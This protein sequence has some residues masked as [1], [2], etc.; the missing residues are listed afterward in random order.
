MR[1]RPSYWSAGFQPCSTDSL[2]LC[3]G[4]TRLGLAPRGRRSRVPVRASAWQVQRLLP[5]LSQDIRPL[6]TGSQKQ[7]RETGRQ[8]NA[9]LSPN[10]FTVRMRRCPLARSLLPGFEGRGLL[11]APEG[12]FSGAG[13]CHNQHCALVLGRTRA[14]QLP[15]TQGRTRL[16]DP[17]LSCP[18]SLAC[19]AVGR[20]AQRHPQHYQCFENT[21]T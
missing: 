19:M 12:L 5:Q 2:K 11:L 8:L 7:A 14:T 15:R 10:L 9:R 18:L 16:S 1:R 13:L 20:K 21:G 6:R 3:A 17:A 4:V